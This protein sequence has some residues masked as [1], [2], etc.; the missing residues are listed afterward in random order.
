MAITEIQSKSLLRIS[1]KIDAWFVSRYH[2][3]LYRGCGHNCVYCDGRAEKYAVE[4]EFGRDVR[5]KTNAVELLARELD[6][7][8]RRKPLPRGFVCFGGGVGD[9]WQPVEQIYG[10]ARRALEL[11]AAQGRPIHVLTKSTLV[12]RDLDLLE[13]INRKSRALLSMS[14][15]SVDADLS[16]FLEPGVSLPAERLRVLR[17][18]KARGI[19]CGMFLMPVVPFLTDSAEEIERSIEAASEN[20]LDYVVCAGMT[21]KPGRQEEY[22][23]EAV[24]KRDPGL[25]ERFRALYAQAGEYGWPGKD[26]ASALSRRF[27]NACRKHKMPMRIPARLFKDW[28]EPDD[29]ILC[30]LEYI[31]YLLSLR[32]QKSGL[33]YAAYRLSQLNRPLPDLSAEAIP[34][35]NALARRIVKEIL[36]TGGSDLYERLSKFEE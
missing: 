19:A 36:L 21:L 2:M 25:P 13:S 23:L 16:A 12:E 5:V 33:G 30:L 3:N 20:G 14:F 11:L 27:F 24:G 8:R 1:K 35:V 4:G 10:L 15:S 29:Y 17:E 9:S 32:G 7:A 31:D 28:I 26:Y 18:A 22:F 34:G 6:P